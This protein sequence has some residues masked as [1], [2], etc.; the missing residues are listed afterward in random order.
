MYNEGDGLDKMPKHS[1]IS[2]GGERREADPPSSMMVAT[3]PVAAASTKID[4]WD[5]C[6][7]N[8]GEGQ[9]MNQP[10][11]RDFTKGAYDRQVQHT[12]ILPP[13]TSSSSLPVYSKYHPSSGTNA[14]SHQYHANRRS[15]AT[16][17]SRQRRSS[18]CGRSPSRSLSPTGRARIL[19]DHNNNNNNNAEDYH[20]MAVDKSN[21]Q[22]VTTN[23]A[24]QQK[25][26][27]KQSSRP[28]QKKQ[29][30]KQDEDGDLVDAKYEARVAL[31]IQ[32]ALMFFCLVVGIAVIMTLI[33]SRHS[34]FAVVMVCVIILLSLSLGLCCFMYQVVNE[35]ESSLPRVNSKHMPKWYRTLTKIVRDELRDFQEDW[36]AMCNNVYLLEDG[37]AGDRYQQ[38]GTDAT[39]DEYHDE[40]DTAP[41][42]HKKRRGKSS[43]FKLVAKP[44]AVFA[45]FRRKRKEKKKQKK[46]PVEPSFPST[47]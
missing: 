13:P 36:K 4:G 44:A 11:F 3:A 35:E 24:K 34:F 33:L 42:K 5:R 23:G 6:R 8:K 30:D 12:E 18:S 25:I 27:S 1:K 17:E 10:A 47:V 9:G 14:N 43:L 38:H 41:V 40:Y 22:P 37:D 15:E 39:A 31:T 16:S 29:V 2:I 20:L 28:R 45:N 46:M 7:E 21:Q 32:M 26:S 19:N